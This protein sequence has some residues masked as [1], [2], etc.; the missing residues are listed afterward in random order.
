MLDEFDE[1]FTP[2]SERTRPQ[3]RSP[4]LR[5]PTPKKKRSGKT[6]E[7]IVSQ[8]IDSYLK[9]IGAITLRTSAGLVQ[10]DAR[11]FS[12]G[13]AGTSDRTCC[14]QGRFVAIEIKAEHGTPTPS[15]E[16]Y[17]DR[18]RSVGG[19]TIVAR[20]VEDV[21]RELIAVFGESEVTA[22]ENRRKAG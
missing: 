7:A 8:K 9:Q 13:A 1:L 3:T 2:R 5:P 12:M 18:V 4:H 11:K 10:I 21:R 22:W 19:L 15:Q 20:S 17:L 6:P 16:K 14:V